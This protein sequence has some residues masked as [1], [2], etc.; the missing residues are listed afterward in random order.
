MAS[1]DGIMFGLIYDDILYLK[2]DA[3]N[4]AD[5]QRL[6]LSQFEYARQG[7]LIAWSYYQ[8]PDFVMEDPGEAAHWARRAFDAALRA[9]ASKARTARQQKSNHTLPDLRD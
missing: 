1:R 6:G 8:A 7:K 3:K 9:D 2:A 5:F 4:I